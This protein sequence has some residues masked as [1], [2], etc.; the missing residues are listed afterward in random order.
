VI[1]PAVT[2]LNLLPKNG[3]NEG[4]VTK[5]FDPETGFGMYTTVQT[6][7]FGDY[8]SFRICGSGECTGYVPLPPP[9]APIVAWIC[10]GNT[11]GIGKGA[12][13]SVRLHLTSSTQANLPKGA[14]FGIPED[15]VDATG[16]MLAG[17]IY[18]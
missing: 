14:F 12:L 3:T 11:E 7:D 5:R 8:G 17:E 10:N 9:S 6:W 1:G 4:Y 2:T 16:M 18:Y 13:R 15:F